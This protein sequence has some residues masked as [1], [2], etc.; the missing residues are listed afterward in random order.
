MKV[1]TKETR[2]KRTSLKNKNK[3]TK[4]TTEELRVVRWWVV[5]GGGRNKGTKSD[6]T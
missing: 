6:T 5:G 2:Y 1:K 4:I 3:I